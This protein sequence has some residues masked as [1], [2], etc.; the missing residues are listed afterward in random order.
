MFLSSVHK[1]RAFFDPQ[2]S[3]KI[4]QVRQIKKKKYK[5][6]LPGVSGHYLQM[7]PGIRALDDGL[8]EASL[9]TMYVQSKRSE[10]K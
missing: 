9:R 4:E 6:A 8:P 3:W 5:D 1:Y 7:P 2:T 10:V